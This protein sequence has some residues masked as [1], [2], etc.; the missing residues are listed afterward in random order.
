MTPLGCLGSCEKEFMMAPSFLQVICYKDA[1]IYKLEDDASQYPL[2]HTALFL[3]F[4]VYNRGNVARSCS[5][6]L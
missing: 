2:L 4:L 6:S 5:Q 3:M 1:A